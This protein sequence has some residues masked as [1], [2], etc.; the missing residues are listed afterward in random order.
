MRI[1]CCLDGS[2]FDQIHTTLQTMFP[3]ETHMLNFLYV[4]D[5]GP[6]REVERKTGPLMRR[7]SP[8]HARYEQMRQAEEFNARDVLAEA[9]IQYSNAETIS[10]QGQPEREIVNYA[11]SWSA[12][13]IL[14][15]P[16]S[17]QR[18]EPVIGPK[19]VG[20]VARFVLDHAPCP[21]LLARP[22]TR[23]HFPL[24]K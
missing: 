24:K 18:N 8:D 6:R 17:P 19:S 13:L 11:A 12:D 4:I 15:C 22:I 3:S 2:N 14:V 23:E 10:R 9:R 1:L 20:H 16:R 7:M 5:S 21:V